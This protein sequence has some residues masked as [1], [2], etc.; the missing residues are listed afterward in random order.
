MSWI[1]A[2]RYSGSLGDYAQYG[3]KDPSDVTEP[4]DSRTHLSAILQL[5]E[6]HDI[7]SLL[8]KAQRPLRL[9]RRFLHRRGDLSELEIEERAAAPGSS[10]AESTI[11]PRAC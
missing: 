8:Q 7:S 1:L 10:A 2:V 11:R 4:V 6:G 3:A 5:P 9:R